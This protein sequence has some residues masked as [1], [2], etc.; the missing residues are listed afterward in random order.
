[1][2]SPVTVATFNKMAEI[3]VV[4][5]DKSVLMCTSVLVMFHEARSIN[6]QIF[7]I[8]KIRVR[9]KF[10]TGYWVLVTGYS[11]GQKFSLPLGTE[12]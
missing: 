10:N 4:T 9:K 2:K 7:K 12:G 6:S 5:E 8:G 11:P 1:M 3:L